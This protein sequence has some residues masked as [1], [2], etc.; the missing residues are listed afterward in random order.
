MRADQTVDTDVLCFS[1]HA[2]RGSLT[3]M[4]NKHIKWL[5]SNVLF[6]EHEEKMLKIVVMTIALL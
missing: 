1:I 4:K 5:F 3:K 6:T 2:D